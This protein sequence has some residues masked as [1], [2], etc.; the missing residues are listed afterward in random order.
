MKIF[1][2]FLIFFLT[3]GGL[4][5]LFAA[6]GLFYSAT[7]VLSIL[8]SVALAVYILPYIS[9]NNEIKSSRLFYFVAAIALAVSLATCY[10]ATPTVFGGRDQG[11]IAAAAIELCQNHNF[12]V[13]SP[14]AHDLF[15]KYGAGRALNFPGFDYTGNGNLISRFPVGFTSYLAAYYNLFGLKGIQYAKFIPLFLFLVIFWRILREFFDSKVSFLGL[16][17]AASF[18]TFFLLSKFTLTEI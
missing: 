4:V 9:L 6:T 13:V 14:V 10:F 3:F 2:G 18:F 16:L 7:V 15:D 5:L 8:M 11:S 1:L 17:I 12:T